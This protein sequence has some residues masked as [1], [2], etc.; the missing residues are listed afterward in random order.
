MNMLPTLYISRIANNSNPHLYLQG[1]SPAPVSVWEDGYTGSE[2][3][4]LVRE[5][6]RT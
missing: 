4:S 2:A 3:K 1:S 5:L 6:W